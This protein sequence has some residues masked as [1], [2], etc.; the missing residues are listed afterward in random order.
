MQNAFR[1]R[2]NAARVAISDQ[3]NFFV[4]QF[5][6]I[7]SEWKADDSRVTFADFAISEKIVAA[8]RAS[9]PEDDFCSEESGNPGEVQELRARYAWVIDP[10]DGTD[11][12]ALGI[13]MCAISLGLL[14]DGEPVYG[15]IYDYG[16]RALLEGGPGQGM[17]IGNRRL[18]FESVSRPI[19]VKSVIGLHFPFKPEIVEQITPLFSG[20]RIRSLGSG[21]L[22]LAYTALGKWDGC[23]DMKVRVWD[24]A[25]AVA[26]LSACGLEPEF[27]EKSPF[28]LREFHTNLETCPY[29]AGS[30][31]F[32]E[33]VR[34]LLKL[35][36]V[37]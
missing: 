3:I 7:T 14:R 36:A 27:I 12:Y 28:P 31:E 13:P 6:D 29:F 30:P 15:F 17:H 18:Q 26:F 5:G 10:I 8:L 2:I 4:S 1:H 9:F 25:A 37:N 32:C 20:C 16:Q 24:I 23:L 19:T 33:R 34:E 21:A 11:N 35:H 22:M